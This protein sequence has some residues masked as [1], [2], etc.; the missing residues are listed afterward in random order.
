M[1]NSRVIGLCL[2]LSATATASPKNK[3][4]AATP[5]AAAASHG[6][7]VVT[8]DKPVSGW[9]TARKITV[10]GA[11]SD[12]KI[13][14]TT[15]SLNGTAFL[16]K[17]EGGRFKQKLVVSEGLNTVVV[18]TENADGRGR[19]TTSFFARVPKVDLKVYL[20]FDPQ[21]F[22]IDLWVTEPGGEKNY[23]A[24]RETPSG[25]VL[26]DLYNDLPGG[27]VGMGPQA[28]TIAN[29]PAGK[30]KIQVNYWAGGW[31]GEGESA[32]GP[33]GARA[34][35]MVPV[36]VETV[37]YEGTPQEERRSFEAVLSKPSDTYTVGEIEVTPPVE[38]GHA[39]VQFIAVDK[40]QK[41]TFRPKYAPPAAASAAEGGE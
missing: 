31:L 5:K 9:T 29:A 16:I 26:H 7:P 10:E 12:P 39:P 2:L 38:R 30:Y 15:L 33:Y 25:G 6:P 17:V 27:A 3:T 35:P 21:P 32:E 23:W 1:A 41:R 8:I 13:A 19:A 36:R 22:Y 24:N 4:R 18:E 34:Q 37:L 40:V 11:I 28:Y 20:M 14:R